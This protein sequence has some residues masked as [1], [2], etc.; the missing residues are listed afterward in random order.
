MVTRLE[1]IDRKRNMFFYYALDIQRDLFGCW[2]LTRQWG[3][4]GRDGRRLIESFPTRNLAAIEADRWPARKVRKG[5][6]LQA[7][8]AQWFVRAPPAKVSEAETGRLLAPKD[9]D[10]HLKP[11][12]QE[13]TSLEAAPSR[14]SVFNRTERLKDSAVLAESSIR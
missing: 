7:Q 12:R 4:I 2:T 9:G 14:G 10:R 13:W 8:E 1:R 3:R 6:Q 11:G 5:Y